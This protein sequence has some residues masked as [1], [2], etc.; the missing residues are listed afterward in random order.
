MAINV[1]T[2]LAHNLNEDLLTRAARSPSVPCAC[3]LHTLASSSRRGGGGC[4]SR[5]ATPAKDVSLSR[6]RRLPP[7]PNFPALRSGTQG[8][9]LQRLWFFPERR[10]LGGELSARQW[11]LAGK[12]QSFAIFYP[13]Q[14]R[15]GRA[16]H[17][18]RICLLERVVSVVSEVRGREE[19]SSEDQSEEARQVYTSLQRRL[20]T[21]SH[22]NKNQVLPPFQ[23]RCKGANP[24]TEEQGEW[25][26]A[27]SLCISM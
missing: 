10:C 16:I 24:T 1:D 21:S 25:R 18:G 6:P 8:F 14:G 15:A 17:C 26:A 13:S 22:K 7:C 23:N 11:R 20:A 19:K 27:F 9:S 2:I 3:L 4:C 5:S 12:L